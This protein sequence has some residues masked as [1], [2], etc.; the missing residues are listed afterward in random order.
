VLLHALSRGEQPSDVRVLSRYERR[1]MP[2]NLAM[3]AAMEGF[4]RLFQANPL[5][6][7]WL[8]NFGLKSVQSLPQ[9]KALFVRQALGLSGDLPDLARAWP[10]P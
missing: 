6:L 2:H 9:A 7:R 3:M 5:P 1:R 8:R 10:R 4:E